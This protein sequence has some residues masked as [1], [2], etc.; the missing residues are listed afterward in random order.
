M[1][2]HKKLR[3]IIHYIKPTAQLLFKIRF[4]KGGPTCRR[5]MYA[6]WILIYRLSM[7][8]RTVS[9]T[10]VWVRIPA[11]P[12]TRVVGSRAPYSYWDWWH[13]II[14]QVPENYFGTPYWPSV[15]EGGGE[16]QL[17][18]ETCDQDPCTQPL[19]TTTTNN[20]AFNDISKH[21]KNWILASFIGV[22]IFISH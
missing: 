15:S 10:A 9:P 22:V 18:A 16:W 11:K 17:K 20:S 2:K 1:S 21:M 7:G 8:C 12:S 14:T 6:V 19:T 5:Q 4:P 3:Y 13:S